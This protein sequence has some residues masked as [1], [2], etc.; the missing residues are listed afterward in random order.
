MWHGVRLQ[1]AM[2]VQGHGRGG[3]TE[4]FPSLESRNH[5]CSLTTYSHLLQLL[6]TGLTFSVAPCVTGMWLEHPILAGAG[7]HQHPGGFAVTRRKCWEVLLPGDHLVL[8]ATGNWGWGWGW[9]GVRKG[10][11][12]VEGGGVW[13]MEGGEGG[14]RRVGSQLHYITSLPPAEPFSFCFI[15]LTGCLGREYGLECFPSLL[16]YGWSPRG[17]Q[18]LA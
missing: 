18:S 6:A 5:F 13:K 8:Q 15:S 17:L 2:C 3:M 7:L 1:G 14:G 11:G 9:V 16:G 4:E 10:W 12:C